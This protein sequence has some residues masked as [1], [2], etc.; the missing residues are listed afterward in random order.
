[1]PR[2]PSTWEDVYYRRIRAGDDP[3]YALFVADEWKKRQEQRPVSEQKQQVPSVGRVVHY[4]SHG[5]PDG[6]FQSQHRAAIITEVY[7]EP[8]AEIDGVQFEV[9]TSEVDLTKA[10]IAVFNPNG[11]YFAQ[12]APYDPTAQQP[13]SWHWPEYVPAK[14]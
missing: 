4:V 5:S 12:H 14:G 1:M 10:G 8:L 2:R 3:A 6:T 9:K 13:G 7:F 11:M